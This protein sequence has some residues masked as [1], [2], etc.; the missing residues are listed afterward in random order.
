VVA[1]KAVEA[2]VATPA[3]SRARDSVCVDTTYIR[4]S[5]DRTRN[6]SN[7]NVPLSQICKKEWRWNSCFKW[8]LV[9]SVRVG[10]KRFV[11]PVLCW[12]SDEA[13]NSEAVSSSVSMRPTC[14]YSRSVNRSNKMFEPQPLHGRVRGFADVAL[15]AIA[16]CWS[17][18]Q[19]S[20]VR[21]RLREVSASKRAKRSRSS[22]V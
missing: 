7:N 13:T 4:N 9:T 5:N 16:G 1:A 8:S 3:A 21:P 12:I 6:M 19:Y 2:A 22:M 10:P 17:R 15:I 20:P 14:R 18:Q 11:K